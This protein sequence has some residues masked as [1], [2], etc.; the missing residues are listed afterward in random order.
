MV[1]R[2]APVA[3]SAQAK[4]CHEQHFRCIFRRYYDYPWRQRVRFVFGAAI[5]VVAGESAV[6]KMSESKTTMHGMAQ[7]RPI[8]PPPD[9]NAPPRFKID[10]PDDISDF[11]AVVD[12]LHLAGARNGGGYRQFA[13]AGPTFTFDQVWALLE[14]NEHYELFRCVKA[15]KQA[16]PRFISRGR[17]TTG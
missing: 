3:D 12:L 1:D 17:I 14:L 5:A 9:P 16:R 4:T 15:S 6:P 7:R 11:H 10:L 2:A 8:P 13:V